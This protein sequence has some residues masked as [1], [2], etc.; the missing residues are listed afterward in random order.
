MGGAG[1]AHASRGDRRLDGR[2]ARRGR[3]RRSGGR[4]SAGRPEG[5]G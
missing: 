1:Q 5:R 4:P 3:R 2:R